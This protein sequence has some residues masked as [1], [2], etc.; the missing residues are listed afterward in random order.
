MDET[1]H[2]KST[3]ISSTYRMGHCSYIYCSQ[4]QKV[5]TGMCIQVKLIVCSLASKS[6]IHA[7]CLPGLLGCIY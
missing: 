5:Y 3:M 4:M 1:A 2:C 6:R 7:V